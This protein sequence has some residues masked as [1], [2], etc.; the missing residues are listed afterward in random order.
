MG[1]IIPSVV[2]RI[3]LLAPTAFFSKRYAR[4]VSVI[5]EG[6][7]PVYRKRLLE[8]GTLSTVVSVV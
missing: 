2:R 8:H 6:S 7:F 1:W 5:K 4:K 3:F